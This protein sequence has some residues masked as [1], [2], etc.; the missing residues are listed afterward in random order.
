MQN[1]I[2]IEDRLKLVQVPHFES[3]ILDEESMAIS[4]HN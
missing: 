1:F 4:N 2:G 3:H